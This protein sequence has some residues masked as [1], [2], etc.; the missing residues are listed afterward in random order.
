[1][2]EFALAIYDIAYIMLIKE[3]LEMNKP[4]INTHFAKQFH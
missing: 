2:S 1:M 3:A 4:R